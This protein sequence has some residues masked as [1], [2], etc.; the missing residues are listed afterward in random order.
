[1]GGLLR[2]FFATFSAVAEKEGDGKEGG[3][4]EGGGMGKFDA[5]PDTRLITEP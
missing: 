4:K 5:R 1:V 2:T 3:G